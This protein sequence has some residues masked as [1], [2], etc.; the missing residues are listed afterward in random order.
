MTKPDSKTKLLTICLPLVPS[1]LRVDMLIL[2][3]NTYSY[4]FLSSSAM[5]SCVGATSYGSRSQDLPSNHK[6]LLKDSFS[7]LVI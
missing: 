2:S 7:N 1:H 5:E 6:V 4:P 3:S